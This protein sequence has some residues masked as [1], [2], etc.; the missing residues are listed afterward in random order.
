MEVPAEDARKK[1]RAELAAMVDEVVR[2][3][4]FNYVNVACAGACI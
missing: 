3:C 4:D 1:E 2:L